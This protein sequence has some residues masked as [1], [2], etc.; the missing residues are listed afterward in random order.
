[1]GQAR[2]VCY[3]LQLL[4]YAHLNFKNYFTETFCHVVNVLGKW[5]LTF[6]KLLQKNCAVN[7]SGKKG[8]AIELDA[9]VESEMVQLLKS[10]VTGKRRGYLQAFVHWGVVFCTPIFL[11]SLFFQSCPPKCLS[12]GYSALVIMLLSAGMKG[13]FE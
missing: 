13:W 11:A 4:T 10:Y 3:I 6:R 1:L 2:E 12:N 8:A 7:L 9:F 5:P